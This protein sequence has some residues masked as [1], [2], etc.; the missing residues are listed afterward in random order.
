VEHIA[1]KRGVSFRPTKL[2]DAAQQSIQAVK[3][4]SRITPVNRLNGIFSPVPQ[5]STQ[6][7]NL[8]RLTIAGILGKNQDH[9]WQP[10]P[11]GEQRVPFTAS[12]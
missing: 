7:S 8:Q 5:S 3:L 11:V 4:T 12:N 9:R 1:A 2:I 10:P 6:I